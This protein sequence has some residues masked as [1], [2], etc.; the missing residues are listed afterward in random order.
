[1]RILFSFL[2][3]F[4]FIGGNA[5]QTL[6]PA[7]FLGYE[8]GEKF[9]PHYKIVQY[10]REMANAH[11]EKM[12]L[13]DYGTTNEGRPLILAV[14]S[15]AENMQRIEEIRKNNLRLTGMLNDKPAD[16][17]MPA[18]VWLSYNVHGNEASSSEVAVKVLYELISA[19]QA[20]IGDWLKQTVVIIDP[21]L[22]P[23]G[24]DR[25][26]NWFNQVVGKQP[27]SDPWAREHDEPWPGG[28]TNHYNFDL[29]RD[30][31]WQ[32]QV[33][34]QSRVKQYNEWMPVIHCDFHEQFPAN[35]YYFAPAAEPFHEVITPWQR[36]FQGTIGRNHARY[37][38]ANGWLYFT[39]EYFDLFYP[40]YGDTYPLYN[41]SIGMTYEQAGHSPAGLAIDVNQSVLKLSDRVAHHFTTSMSTLEVAAANSRKINEEFGK[42]FKDVNTNGSGLYTSY[43]IKGTNTGKIGAL[44][45]LFAKNGIRYEYAKAGTQ[46]KGFNYFSGKEDVYQAANGDIVVSTI[47]PKGT[48]VRVLFEPQSKLVDSSTYDITAW[49]VPYAYGIQAYA[50]RDKVVTTADQST[51]AISQPSKSEYAYLVAYNSYRDGKFLAAMLKNGMKVRF[52]EKNF[53]FA[54]KQYPK[55]TLIILKSGNETQLAKFFE[56]AKTNAV[57]L[58][59]VS[60]GFMDSGVDFGSDKVHLLRK[61]VVAML[62]GESVSSAAAGEIWHM[63]DHQLD[64]PLMLVN[65]SSLGSMN[66]K[67]IDVIIIP[68]GQYR[69]LADKES[70]LRTWVKQGGKIIAM[71]N[72]V[73]QMA[74]GDWGV[75]IKKDEEEKADEKKPPYADIKKYEDRD[76]NGLIYNTPGAIYKVELDDSHPLAFGYSSAYYTLKINT[77]LI[78]FMK[79]GW[80][81]GI[82]KK[83]NIVSGFVGS[84]VKEKMKDG[85]VLAVQSYGSG[86]V[87]SFTDNPVFRSF[88]EDGKLLLT[89]AIFL[90]G[91]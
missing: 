53:S 63:F 16:I 18:I 84:V 82:I 88:W 72:A 3:L 70:N 44:K 35:P 2:L 11:P 33:E 15:S 8:P 87:V 52:S 57:E 5:Q 1:M 77:N 91:Q 21:C 47:Q 85:T 69:F 12:K 71:E 40:A 29:N 7:T 74:S 38:D 22:N 75:K 50:S 62:T 90:V 64:Y 19:Q 14:V 80:N 66:L 6:S 54:G 37:F 65:A 51:V 10:F 56:L 31:A 27:I 60:S 45:E 68:D 26:V 58:V 46:V 23:D 9:T 79:D 43:V 41:G 39:K 49:S 32:T 28:R 4:T 83:E 30:W 76:R 24:R 34:S 25:Y 42:F 13:I 48:L 20:N 86:T 55:G 17:N 78:E 36:S 81:V 73:S 59:S 61:P 67:N 89:N